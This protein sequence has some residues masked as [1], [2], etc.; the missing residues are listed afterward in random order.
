[1]FK[2][3]SN[4]LKNRKGFTLVELMVVVVVIGILAA[5]AIPQFTGAKDAATYAAVKANL[6]NIDSAVAQYAALHNVAI[7]DVETDD[8]KEILTQW[9][10]GSPAAD[11]TYG[12][13][14][15]G[16]AEIT[17]IG[18]GA[19]TDLATGD[20]FASITADGH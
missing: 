17:A 6:K 20:T 10:D 9:P 8:A 7:A 3:M 16:V 4:K 19:P 12:V 1:M 18:T 5:I 13:N 14:D 2:N 11:Y 15:S